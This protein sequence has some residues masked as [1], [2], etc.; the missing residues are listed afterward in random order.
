M[1]YGTISSNLTYMQ[2]ESQKIQVKTENMFEEIMVV[3]LTN[4]MKIINPQK[5][6]INLKQKK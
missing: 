4:L 3:I 6:S 5:T 2:I 1:S